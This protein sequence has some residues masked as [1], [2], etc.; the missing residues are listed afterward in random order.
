MFTLDCTL[1]ELYRGTKQRYRISQP[2]P[3]K[4]ATD[5]V[6]I[7]I[8]PGTLPGTRVPISLPSQRLTFVINELPHLHFIRVRSHSPAHSYDFH[9]P[10]VTTLSETPN[11]S[12]HLAMCVE[13]PYS[14][15]ED[16]YPAVRGPPGSISFAG[17]SGA[18]LR[19]MLPRTLVEA[20]DGTCVRGQGMPIYDSNARRVVGYG[21]LFI[22]WD[23]F[24]PGSERRE[25]K[26]TSIKKAMQ[27]SF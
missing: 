7:N 27:F 23:L 11:T 12:P 13:M 10:P 2:Y 19:V 15:L 3:D 5:T 6:D 1:E 26:W 20:S 4:R 9:E 21:D 25:S 16:S 18:M 22:R 8:P 14:F 24:V 17:P